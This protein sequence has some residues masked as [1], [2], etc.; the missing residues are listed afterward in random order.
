MI[1]KIV[2][3][4]CLMVQ[5]MMPQS[6]DSLTVTTTDAGVIL[7][8]VLLFA[9]AFVS[10][11]SFHELGHYSIGLLCGAG[12]AKF[13]LYRAKP[14]GGHQIGWTDVGQISSSVGRMGVDIGGVLFSRGLAEGAHAVVASG[15]LP[16]IGNRFVSMIFI[17][18]R[19]DFSRYVIQD[20]MLNMFGRKGSDIDNFV[21]E[22]A[23]ANTAGR[24]LT[25]GALT[26]ISLYDVISDWNRITNHWG[27]LSGAQ[28]I[29]TK[30][31]HVT[32]II[33]YVTAYGIGI[34]IS[35]H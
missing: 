22:I 10:F 30:V 18:G 26:A 29:D 2:F 17:L 4:I 16:P 8:D 11:I 32:R 23:G 15:Y 13:G 35:Y 1:K 12:N 31:S 20:A 33:P 25:Y 7:S 9:P 6:S 3:C 27:V 21:T 19:F 24:T 34:S 28:G 5:M 14:N